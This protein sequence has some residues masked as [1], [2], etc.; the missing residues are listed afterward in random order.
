[1]GYRI[2]YTTGQPS[3]K[4]LSPN[5]S[6]KT[7]KITA[8]VAG[9]VLC[10]GMLIACAEPIRDFLIPGDRQVTEAAFQEMTEDLRDGQGLRD[11]FAVFCQKI[12]DGAQ[13]YE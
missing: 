11:A 6:Q 7:L 9:I 3:R 5:I 8:I 13:G 10:A 1:M 4:K 2:D 12:L